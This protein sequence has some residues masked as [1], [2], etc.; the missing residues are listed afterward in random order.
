MRGFEDA[1]V[2]IVITSY[3]IH[4]TKLYD[5]LWEKRTLA[6]E[7]LDGEDDVVTGDRGSIVPDRVLPEREVVD[8]AF[9]VHTPGF[10]QVCRITSYNVCYTKLLLDQ[11]TIT[12]DGEEWSA[13]LAPRGPASGPRTRRSEAKPPSGG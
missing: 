12:G 7:H 10:G 4:Y 2:T 3:S 13:G 6:F 8:R 11:V 9:L 1:P 5:V